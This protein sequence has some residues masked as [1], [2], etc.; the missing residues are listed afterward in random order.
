M[1]KFFLNALS[2]F[3][4][5][6]VAIVL[7]G[8]VAVLMVFALAQ[9]ALG[10]SGV[11]LGKNTVL[12]VKLSGVFLERDDQMGIGAFDLLKGD[13]SSAQS[14][15]TLVNAITEAKT[16]DL[17]DAIYLDCGVVE[18]A[19]ASLY[20]I[21]EA[22]LDF[23]TSEKKIYAYGDVYSQGAYFVA[24]VA[25]EMSLNP[26]GAVSFQGLGGQTLFYKGLFDKLG[27]EFQVVRVG[28]GKAAVEPY[29]ADTMSMVARTQS[30]QMMDTLWMQMRSC[31][32]ESRPSVTPSAMDSLI[33][34]E[35]VSQKPAQFL[36]AN[37][38][39]DRLE[40]RH[41]FE[42]RVAKAVGQDKKLDNRIS[43]QQL[44]SLASYNKDS[45]ANNQIAVL[46]ACGAIDDVMGG[47]GINSDKLVDDILALSEND[48]VKALVL[49]VNS[50]GGSA[51]G[52][53]QI[54]EALQTFKK[55][56][57]PFVVS[58]GDY[59]AS[60]GYYISCGADRIF[61]NPFTIT[62]SIGIF[63]LIPNVDGLMH[64]LGVN[65]EMVATNPAGQFPTGLT[66]LNE[67]QMAAMQSMVEEG[68]QLF[69]KRCAEG[70][71]VSVAKIEEIAD[72]RPLPA[73]MAK[74]YG[75]VD[76]LGTLKEAVAYAAKQAKLEDYNVVSYPAIEITIF[77]MLSDM[78]MNMGQTLSIAK[79]LMSGDVG[80]YTSVAQ[81]LMDNLKAAC[82]M[83]AE[84]T[85]FKFS[86]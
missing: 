64:K 16:N 77:K 76:E 39:V 71:K 1:K 24:S 51:F 61:A 17:I 53:E 81:I 9:S 32:A 63:G 18:A 59:A 29:T 21:R 62:G 47:G 30:L 13:L 33:N 56:G 86:L 85:H 11:A 2:S 82:P 14:V 69:V 26:A 66:P 22:L 52:S 15:E 70:R 55:T 23:K 68:Y 6:W 75:L 37:K 74:S 19:P 40:Y 72:G 54:W 34:V 84:A 57:R 4:G 73:V 20:A 49:R 31:I 7:A 5:A 50:P 45:S 35:Y 83:R 79:L 80:Q 48:N 3:V 46:Y 10:G 8:V 60:G 42:E 65:V 41:S 27:V 43:P 38:L 78:Q 44:N 12:D 58:M 67:D 28:K 25:N 36:L